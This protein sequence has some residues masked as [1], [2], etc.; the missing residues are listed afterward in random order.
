MSHQVA[1]Y[2]SAGMDGHLSKPIEIARL[3]EVV[4]ACQASLEDAPNPYP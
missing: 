1:E 3:F 4:G 2:L